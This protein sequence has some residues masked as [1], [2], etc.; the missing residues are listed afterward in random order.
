MLQLELAL[1]EAEQREAEQQDKIE[2]MA[3]RGLV[4]KANTARL[5]HTVAHLPVSR[6]SGSTPLHS[7]RRAVSCVPQV[8]LKKAE[9]EVLQARMQARAAQEHAR[10]AQLQAAAAVGRTQE[11][12]HAASPLTPPFRAGTPAAHCGRTVYARVGFLS[13]RGNAAT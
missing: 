7:T 3:V 12:M 11:A 4:L 6:M 13:S 10:E 1:D 5:V 2:K 8:D 9:F